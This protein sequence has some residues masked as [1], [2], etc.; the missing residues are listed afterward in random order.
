MNQ[1]TPHFPRSAGVAAFISALTFAALLASQAVPS[2]AQTPP[3]AGA[4]KSSAPTVTPARAQLKSE[5]K[6]LAAAVVAAEE[7]L[8]PEELAI[9]ERVY[10]GRLPCELGE[11]VILV[12]DAKSPGYFDLQTRKAKF[13]M[14][15]VPTT[16]GTV[17]LED[18]KAGAV[19]LQLASKSMLMNAKAGQRLA[20]ECMGPDQSKASAALKA[21]PTSTLLDSVGITQ[22][23]KPVQ[24]D[25]TIVPGAASDAAPSA[26]SDGQTA[27]STPVVQ[28][29]E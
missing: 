22:L 24:A 19:W 23:R 20:D 10:V 7:A 5:A 12:A 13:R 11:A 3:A 1:L 16:T 14:F 17:R 27:T 9:A 18:K 26:S 4:K 29:N 28:K 21:E 25:V 8:T 15:P 6:N 2:M